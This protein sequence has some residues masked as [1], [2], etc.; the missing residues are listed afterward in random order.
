MYTAAMA[1]QEANI[2]DVES[3][4]QLQATI[5]DGKWARGPWAGKYRMHMLDSAFT[6]TM[7]LSK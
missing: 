2:V 1:F 6:D 4:E 5:A 7:H 3:Y